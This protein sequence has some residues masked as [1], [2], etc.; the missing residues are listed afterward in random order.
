MA[1]TKVTKAM[2]FAR[3]I[4]R[5]GDD[6]EI[7]A[8][9]EN[10]LALIEKKNVKAKERNA[11]KRAIGDELQAVVLGT[12]SA[13]PQTRDDILPAV[14]EATGDETL[15]VGKIQSKLNNLVEAG[16][17]AKCKV[18]TEEGKTKTAYTVCTDAE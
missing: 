2:I 12:I 1:E 6:E 14:I 16:K 9:M 8:C 10:E 4:E 5:C 17:I 13:D 18:K 3:V 15:T 11:K 7:V